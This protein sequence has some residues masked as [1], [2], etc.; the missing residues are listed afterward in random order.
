[1]ITYVE[2]GVVGISASG[3]ICEYNDELGGCGSAAAAA[4]EYVVVQA[5]KPG[6]HVGA[7]LGALS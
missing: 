2:L 1:M 7:C 5:L 6:R 3:A 4:R